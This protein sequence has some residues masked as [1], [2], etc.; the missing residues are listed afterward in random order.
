MESRDHDC[1][2]HLCYREHEWLETHGLDC[3]PYEHCFQEW[4]ECAVCGD[5]FTER[6]LARMSEE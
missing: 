6:E 4:W 2:D 5:Q 1:L 3:G